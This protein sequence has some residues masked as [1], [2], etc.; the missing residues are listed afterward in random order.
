MTDIIDGITPNRNIINTS[1]PTHIV[2]NS[3]ELERGGKNAPGAFMVKASHYFIGG[4]ALAT[5][6]MWN[7]SI[8]DAI[9][10]KFPIP[11]DNV[12]ANFV[13]AIIIT[14]MLVVLI[15]VLPDTKSELPEDTQR[16]IANEKERY[17]LRAKVSAQQIK[18]AELERAIGAYARP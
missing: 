13:F 3:V 14:A 9:K 7:R 15:Y 17:E 11:E 18:L 8:Q 2:K 5:A 16:K 10:Q 6:L 12:R 4:F 1:D